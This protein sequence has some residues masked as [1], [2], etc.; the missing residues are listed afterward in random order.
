M[1]SEKEEDPDVIPEDSSLLTLRY[2][3]AVLSRYPYLRWRGKSAWK[4]SWLPVPGNAFWSTLWKYC[5]G[6][7]TS[8]WWG[9][10]Y[11]SSARVLL[12]NFLLRHTEY[13]IFLAGR[14][15]LDL[16]ASEVVPKFGVCRGLLIIVCVR[17]LQRNLSHVSSNSQ[18]YC[19]SQTVGTDSISR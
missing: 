7:N 15:F 9:H 11:K 17:F 12:R 13:A 19:S 2:A 14:G 8:L 18:S 6:G 1:P 5:K 4:C 16:G 10:W 3:V